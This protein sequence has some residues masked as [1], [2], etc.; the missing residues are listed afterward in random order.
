MRALPCIALTV[1]VLLQAVP[2]RADN[3]EVARQAFQEG[4][5]LYDLNDFKSAVESFKKAYL[6]YEEPV[7]L[8]NIAQC[9][10]QLN[11][12]PEAVKFYKNYLRKAPAASNAEEVRQVI[13]SLETAITR[14]KEAASAP[15][16]GT[17]STTES[18]APAPA[19]H[20]AAVTTTEAPPHKKPVYKKWWFWTAIGGVLVAGAVVAIV[21]T[22]TSHPEF[23]PT[24]PEFGPTSTSSALAGPAVRF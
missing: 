24:L 23:K 1:A 17:A 3:K 20:A 19:T 14:E 6:N 22:T 2:A 12:K 7:F 15:P 4:R 10:R 5:R 18:V 9:Y 13:A 11:D 21:L 8:F 16:Q